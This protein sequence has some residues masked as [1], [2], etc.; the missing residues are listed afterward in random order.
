M[1]VSN[2]S[3]GGVVVE[4]SEVI[5]DEGVIDGV[6]SSGGVEIEE[7]PEVISYD[8]DY[9]SERLGDISDPIVERAVSSVEELDHI[10][11]A[12]PN[13]DVIEGRLVS[14]YDI[15]IARDEKGIIGA[16][17]VHDYRHRNVPLIFSSAVIEEMEERYQQA[18]SIG[19]I[20]WTSEKN[21]SSIPILTLWGMV[22]MANLLPQE[23]YVGEPI[24]VSMRR[25]EIVWL[26]VLAGHV[27]YEYLNS[28]KD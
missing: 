5:E 10:C 1:V 21:L 18:T 9:V 15:Q 26:G 28:N 24:E 11:R 6:T 22:Y 16:A 20:D 19:L 7:L 17:A 27:L 4:G 23:G 13:C 14:L 8:I 2:V 25:M 12:D 3:G